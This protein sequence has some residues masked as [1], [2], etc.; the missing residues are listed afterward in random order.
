MQP[1][2]SGRSPRN[3]P[4]INVHF[5]AVVA[6]SSNVPIAAMQATDNCPALGDGGKR[7]ESNVEFT[8][9]CGK[10]VTNY[11]S[12]AK[13]QYRANSLEDCVKDC[14]LTQS[15]VSLHFGLM[16]SN[17]L[18]QNRQ[19]EC[20]IWTA[21]LGTPVGVH[22]DFV[23]VV[24][25]RSKSPVAAMQATDTCPGLGE[26]K[27]IREVSMLT[28]IIGND[29]TIKKSVNGVTFGFSC[30]RYIISPITSVKP[31]FK[32]TTLFECVQACAAESSCRHLHWGQ[33][34]AGARSGGC[35]LLGGAGNV[36]F[37]GASNAWIAAVAIGR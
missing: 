2:G 15:C 3:S 14:P 16:N 21:R 25:D 5:V 1:L 31:E 24:A 26:L 22:A 18:G 30:D 29:Q 19:G 35:V 34:A 6:D 9:W 37:S 33:P 27:P 12:Y 32:T 7:T 10:Y 20:N 8:F 11:G 13:P 4:G 36:E 17:T 23:A 28:N